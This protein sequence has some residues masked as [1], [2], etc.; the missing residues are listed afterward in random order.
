[1]G[2]ISKEFNLFKRNVRPTSERY[3][4]I[5]NLDSVFEYLFVTVN[6]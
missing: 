1:M 2:F 6:R 4:K 3:Y 5:D